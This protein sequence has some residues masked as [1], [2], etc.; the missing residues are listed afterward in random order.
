[1]LAVAGAT[2]AWLF[3]PGA[4]PHAHFVALAVDQYGDRGLPVNLWT[5]Q[6]RT[7]LRDRGWQEKNAFT[8]QQRN[9]FLK[10]LGDLGKGQPADDPLVI[11]LCGHV[12]T[13]RDGGLDFLP[14]DAGLGD[15]NAWVPMADVMRLIKQS[16]AKQR[17]LL[18]DVMQPFVNLREGVLYDDAA[19]RAAA[20]LREAADDD[21]GLLV[22]CASSPGQHSL[23]SEEL[24][25]TVFV[26]YLLQGLSGKADGW[27]DGRRL[28]NRV[29]AREL[30]AF[31]TAH[32]D[33]WASRNRG[34]RQTPLLL[35]AQDTDFSLVVCERE[36]R[37]EPAPLNRAY[38]E[39][40]RK[41]WDRRDQWLADAR[42]RTPPALVRDLEAAVLRAEERWRGGADLE[43]AVLPDLQTTVREID[44]RRKAPPPLAK[45]RSLA[46]AVAGGLKPPADVDPELMRRLTQLADLR[47]RGAATPPDAAAL[48][49]LDDKK[50]ALLKDYDNKPF[51]LAWTLFRAA[52]KD[53]SL[54]PEDLR[55]W[56]ALLHPEGKPAPDYAEVALLDALAA[57]PV[58]TADTDWPAAAVAAALELTDE[59]EQAEAQLRLLAPAVP[60]WLKEELGYWRDAAA[61]KRDEARAL[62]LDAPAPADRAKSLQPLK[63]ALSG[64]R[65]Y[66]A[67]KDG[68]LAVRAAVH[69]RDDAQDFLAAFAPYLEHD[70][71]RADD[72]RAAVDQTRALDDLL[73]RKSPDGASARWLRAV[74]AQRRD[75]QDVLNRLRRPLESARLKE[76]IDQSPR[77][78]GADAEELNALLRT[79]ALPAADRVMLWDGWRKLAGRLNDE[80][81]APEAALPPGE[82]PAD[83]PSASDARPEAD[84]HDLALLRAR[85]AVDL[86]RLDGAADVSKLQE[87]ARNPADAAAWRALGRQLYDA[88]KKQD[89]ARDR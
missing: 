59:A 6:D 79:T 23:A 47:L 5:D 32:V 83:A 71:K 31:V 17:L 84:P 10:E 24:G 60:G 3:Y 88:F 12:Q 48:T 73:T 38:P 1:M 77:S 74:A 75:L 61:Q 34:L 29:S 46:E 66:T 4:V 69:V 81:L 80:T 62:L 50:K 58:K 27:N 8:S 53:A 35:G 87:A 42:V 72:W 64:E 65:G 25:H 43:K 54:R 82:S 26:Y 18:V 33:R 39:G 37:V 16:P 11:Y 13:A 20:V 63:E 76:L 68:V 70:R 44:S 40:L 7:A 49:Q 57:L 30:A 21:P 67:L 2:V 28:D 36:R 85:T 52:R 22:L 78:G 56:S 89:D 45:P 51:E 19:A 9:L 55:E 14:G 15:E 86:L 41:E